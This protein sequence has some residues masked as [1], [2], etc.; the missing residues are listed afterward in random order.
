MKKLILL[1]CVGFMLVGCKP[2]EIVKE[3]KTCTFDFYTGETSYNM[4]AENDIVKKVD[5]AVEI[6]SYVVD[7]NVVARF[8]EMEKEVLKDSVKR[9]LGLKYIESEINFDTSGKNLVAIITLDFE[10]M[11]DEEVE[12]INLSKNQKLS[13]LVENFKKMGA[14]CN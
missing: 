4:Q 9:Q 6:P 13:E 11:S 8:N 1:G 10:K 7:K 2:T 3:S 5:M 14:Y 12:K